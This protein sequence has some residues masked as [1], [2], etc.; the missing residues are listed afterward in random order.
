MIPLRPQVMSQYIL[1]PFQSKAKSHRLPFQQK[2]DGLEGPQPQR[3]NQQSGLCSVNSPGST[4]RVVPTSLG[5]S[6]GLPPLKPSSHALILSLL[7][8]K[9]WNWAIPIST[10]LRQTSLHLQT[11]PFFVLNILF[12][13]TCSSHWFIIII[14]IIILTR[15]HL[16]L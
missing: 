8:W 16:V 13:K 15:L 7:P 14:M 2:G 4:F 9:I 6:E 3:M 1:E 11:I 12:S 5:S 10:S